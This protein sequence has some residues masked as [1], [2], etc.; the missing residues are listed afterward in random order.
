MTRGLLDGISEA[1]RIQDELGCSTDDAFTIWRERYVKEMKAL[2]AAE[3]GC[4]Y[5][6]DDNVLHVINFRNQPDEA[7]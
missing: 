4:R 2:T 5:F 6:A 1:M 7:V 3:T